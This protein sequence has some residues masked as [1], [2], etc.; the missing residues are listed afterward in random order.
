MISLIRKAAKH[1]GRTVRYVVRR[2]PTTL[3][4]LKHSLEFAYLRLK[5][6]KFTEF[7]AELQDKKVQKGYAYE[8]DGIG[9]GQFNFLKRH[10]LEPS[11]RLLDIGCGN[12]RGGIHAISFLN[13]GNYAGMDISVEAINDG[14]EI[15]QKEG[16]KNKNPTLIVNDDLLFAEFEDMQFDYVL[17]QSVFTHLPKKSLRECFENVQTVMANDAAFFMTYKRDDEYRFTPS[18]TIENSYSTTYPLGM[19]ANIGC[20]YGLNVSSVD[21]SEHPGDMQMLKV[22]RRTDS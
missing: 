8:R 3:T 7:Y 18:G 6:P 19:L 9:T 11:D 20:E 13:K 17:A 5:N 22:T 16:L 21:Y 10:G 1:P 14:K 4:E 12:L 15:I 2:T